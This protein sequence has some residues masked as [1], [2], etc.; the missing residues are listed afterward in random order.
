MLILVNIRRYALYDLAKGTTCIFQGIVDGIGSERSFI[1][2]KDLQ[3]Y[4]EVKLQVSRLS[5]SCFSLLGVSSV[6][7]R[8][9]LD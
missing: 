7:L 4:Q 1:S 2:H 5:I 3:T 6:L 9:M 8:L